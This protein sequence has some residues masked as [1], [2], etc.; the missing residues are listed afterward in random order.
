VAPTTWY[1]KAWAVAPSI[2]KCYPAEREYFGLKFGLEP[3]H[4]DAIISYS[5]EEYAARKARTIQYFALR[6]R[7]FLNHPEYSKFSSEHSE[8]LFPDADEAVKLFRVQPITFVDDEACSDPVSYITKL[9]ALAEVMVPSVER[10]AAN[11]VFQEILVRVCMA[12]PYGTG[13]R[14]PEPRQ[15]QQPILTQA[16][17]AMQAR[18][19]ER[20]GDANPRRAPSRIDNR[21][22]VQTTRARSPTTTQRQGEVTD[23]WI[24][25]QVK[26]V[27]KLT[28]VPPSALLWMDLEQIHKA[29]N[30]SL[31]HGERMNIA[32]RKATMITKGS[33][34][35]R[36]QLKQGGI[37]QEWSQHDTLQSL[38]E[39]IEVLRSSHQD[40]DNDVVVQMITPCV[41]LPV[42]EWLGVY[43]RVIDPQ[44]AGY[45]DFLY[46]QL[47]KQFQSTTVARRLDRA[48]EEMTLEAGE[49]IEQLYQR[50]ERH[51]VQMHAAGGEADVKPSIIQMRDALKRVFV[52]S[53]MPDLKHTV[54]R[55][56]MSGADKLIEELK[57]KYM[58]TS[59][60]S[61]A[62]DGW[63]VTTSSKRTVSSRQDRGNAN[64]V[65]LGRAKW[66]RNDPEHYRNPQGLSSRKR[67][68]DPSYTEHWCKYHLSWAHATE[69]CTAAKQDGWTEDKPSPYESRR[70][71]WSGTGDRDEARHT[72][73]F[74]KPSLGDGSNRTN[75]GS[76]RVL[77]F[78][79]MQVAGQEVKALLDSGADHTYVNPDMVDLTSSDVFPGQCLVE[80]GGMSMESISN[81]KANILVQIASATMTEVLSDVIVSRANRLPVVLGLPDMRQL[82]SS[83]NL[84]N[85]S[86]KHKASGAWVTGHPVTSGEQ[87]KL[88][89]SKLV[90]R[91][92]WTATGDTSFGPGATNWVEILPDAEVS[93]GA[94][95]NFQLFEKFAGEDWF[96]VLQA[97]MVDSSTHRWAVY[98]QNMR[99]EP[100][101]L[102]GGTSMLVSAL[103]D[104]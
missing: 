94:V 22:T 76:G 55:F 25:K 13:V 7:E 33:Q 37:K 80:Y 36:E 64:D 53:K 14:R 72:N 91:V 50:V 3:G 35:L 100:R 67:R 41:S 24:D 11:F 51:I 84:D 83:W 52:N 20:E 9:A 62:D 21:S 69:K 63:G 46:S 15:L 5:P 12:P 66:M 2:Y 42:R 60:S 34:A 54:D 61:D 81:E 45:W 78:I 93:V 49:T 77:L 28:S 59:K 8:W 40:V 68:D 73:I 58:P 48:M 26:T 90:E 96:P 6:C 38:R 95:M 85:L 17:P 47:S 39:A 97:P 31:E 57:W 27:L 104:A 30:G 74:S 4:Y 102:A 56:Y 89:A 98:V 79:D 99:A 70:T 87:A 32:M 23:S 19:I 65:P 10:A 101:L 16:I 18:V 71:G 43:R 103:A 92:T 82:F 44:Y 75:N 29:S 86:V 1:E 88:F